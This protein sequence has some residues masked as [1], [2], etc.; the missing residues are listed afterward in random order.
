MSY[1]NANSL[2]EMQKR[3]QLRANQ[4][5]AKVTSSAPAAESVSQFT[6]MTT[7]QIRALKLSENGE[8][9]TCSSSKEALEGVN[10]LKGILRSRGFGCY[11]LHNFIWIV[12]F[13]HQ[14]IHIPDFE[15]AK[16][17]LPNLK[18]DLLEKAFPN[19]AALTIQSVPQETER[20]SIEKS[21][22][23]QKLAKGLLNLTCALVSGL[24]FLAYRVMNAC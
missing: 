23:K 8:F 9:L 14:S 16:G 17:M 18:A 11:A 2:E 24:S 20:K 4:N 6:S 15:R 5:K 7:A 3:L 21:Q 10:H 19:E 1:Q 12:P 22:A 13:V